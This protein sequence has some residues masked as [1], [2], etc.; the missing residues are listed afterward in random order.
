MHRLSNMYSMDTW[1]TISHTAQGTGSRKEKG[2]KFLLLFSELHQTYVKRNL[3]SARL[4]IR[5]IPTP[6]LEYLQNTGREA[7]YIITAVTRSC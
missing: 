4:P 6:S 7:C 5:G 2:V 1:D 3:H